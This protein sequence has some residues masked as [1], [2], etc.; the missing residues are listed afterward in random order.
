MGEWE[1]EGWVG[2]VL[3]RR[4]SGVLGRKTDFGS[5]N[6]RIAAKA[7]AVSVGRAILREGRV[8]S[9]ESWGGLPA[10]RKG[11]QALA[12]ESTEEIEGSARP[13]QWALSDKT[14]AQKFVTQKGPTKRLENFSDLREGD[15]WKFW[16]ESDAD[17][18]KKSETE[19]GCGLRS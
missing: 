9:R 4:R 15:E 18:I 6:K 11:S 3:G 7:C 10:R 17:R 2:K 1:D 19:V 5:K 14:T 12:P 8:R 13:V 16:N